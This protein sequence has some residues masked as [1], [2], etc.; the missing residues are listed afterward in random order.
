MYSSGDA[1]SAANHVRIL[2]ESQRAHEGSQSL[3]RDED[4]AEDIARLKLVCEALWSFCSER[5]G[6]TTD[7][8][9]DRMILIDQAE[10]GRVDGMHHPRPRAC[11]ECEAMVPAGRDTCL[12]C[13]TEVPGRDP[14]D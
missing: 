8:L 4:L 11:P 10:D 1:Q 13:A 3:Q 5:L 2:M 12:Y 9:R 7:Q 6:I 14:F